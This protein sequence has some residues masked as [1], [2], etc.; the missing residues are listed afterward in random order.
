M[1]GVANGKGLGETDVEK[2]KT[3]TIHVYKQA[4]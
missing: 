1:D 3:S 2:V 4:I